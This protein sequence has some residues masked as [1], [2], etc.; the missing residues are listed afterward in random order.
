MF[1][2]LEEFCATQEISFDRHS[3][4]KYEWDAENVYFRPGMEEP[5]G[6]LSNNDRD[7]LFPV[8]RIRPVVKDLA[9]LTQKAAT[10]AGFRE[11][12]R[13]VKSLVAA[14]PP[15]IEPLPPLEIVG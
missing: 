12:D 9:E 13:L 4:A 2:E 14:L 10:P 3:D 5:V 11:L 8:G 1:E 15:E 6:V 7:D